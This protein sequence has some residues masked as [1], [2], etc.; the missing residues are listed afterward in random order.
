MKKLLA[1][2]LV[3]FLLIGGL[4]NIAA[5]WVMPPDVLDD[6]Y[7]IVVD[8]ATLATFLQTQAVTFQPQ[9]AKASLRALDEPARQR[10]IE[11]YVR[12]EVLFREAMAL[13]LDRGDEIIRRRLIQK[14]DYIAEGFYN[15]VAPLD[16]VA[17]LAYFEAHR[18]DY[19]VPAKVTFAHI[20]FSF[21]GRSESVA[22]QLAL[23]TLADLQRDVVSTADAASYGERFLYH[24]NYA[25]RSDDEIASHFGRVFQSELF[26]L[27][28]S[29]YWQGPIRSIYGLHLISLTKRTDGR[30]PKFSDVV[31][32]V[33]AD[34]QRQQ[35]RDIKRDSIERLRSQYRVVDQGPG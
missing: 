17:L 23:K 31:E 7:A 18:D 28:P 16:E 13:Q 10:L 32:A 25:G 2:P 14:M 22:E 29:K 5:Q 8:D 12:S 9:Q 34:A 6:R 21:D 19:W 24:R 20:F 15:E 35:Q 26:S 27:N 4:M 30:I 33:L 3:Q 1:E 11:E